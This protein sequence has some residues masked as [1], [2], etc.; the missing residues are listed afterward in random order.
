[1]DKDEILNLFQRVA[2][3]EILPE[4]AH[5]MMIRYPSENLGFACLDHHRSLRDNFPEVV[6]C[7][8]KT[9]E[10]ITAIMAGLERENLNLLATRADAGIYNAVADIIPDAKYNEPGR[11]IYLQRKKT[12][13]PEKRALVISAGTADM[14]VAEETVTCLQT[15]GAEVE[16]AY[17]IG[18]AGLH[19]VIDVLPSLEKAGVVVVVAGMEGALASVIAGLTSNPVIAVPTSVGYGASFNGLA[20]L[21][22]M[23]NSCAGG[24]GVVNIDNGYG[25]AALAFSILATKYG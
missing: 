25:A 8:G 23:L 15:M 20:A 21:L 2:A 18:V 16:K 9:V 17:D 19:R 24:I 4:Q 6:F 13:K 7:Q 11:V 10:Q 14:P 3:G 5:K 1:M 12:F 22:S